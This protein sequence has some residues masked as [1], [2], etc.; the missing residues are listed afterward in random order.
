M[1]KKISQWNFEDNFNIKEEFEVFQRECLTKSS[2]VKMIYKYHLHLHHA[3]YHEVASS[4][5]KRFYYYGLYALA[6]FIISVCDHCLKTKNGK[7]YEEIRPVIFYENN[8]RGKF[9]I[10][11]F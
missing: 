8:V 2:V 5:T 11:Y 6:E 3:H 9:E 7:V 1:N 10:F 4:M